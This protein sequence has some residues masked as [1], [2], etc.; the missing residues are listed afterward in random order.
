MLQFNGEKNVA[1]P[2]DRLFDRFSDPAF[3]VE[4]IPGV[5]NVSDRQPTQVT[6]T[7]RPGFS[8]LRGTLTVTLRITDSL[9]G[10]T[11]HYHAHGK[12]IGSHNDVEATITFEPIGEQSTRLAW[13]AR[14]TQL[15]G[16]LKAVPKGLIQAT[17]DKVINDIWNNIEARLSRET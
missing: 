6:F 11:I 3:L 5:E 4:S 10:K 17:A 16:L 9:P 14:I 8:F 7:L 15:G 12:A 13:E 1:L 2:A